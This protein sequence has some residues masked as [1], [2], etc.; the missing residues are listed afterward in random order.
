ML[1]T[2]SRAFWLRTRIPAL[3]RVALCNTRCSIQWSPQAR[4][5][6]VRCCAPTVAGQAQANGV[7]DEGDDGNGQGDVGVQ[8]V[9]VDQLA[10]QP[11][12]GDEERT[13]GDKRGAIRSQVNF[14]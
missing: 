9:G 6:P 3:P 4:P 7:E 14:V 12:D 5:R 1:I 8:L 2:S 13:C 11:G 10:T